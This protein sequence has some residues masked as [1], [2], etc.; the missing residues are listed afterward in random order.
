MGLHS[1]YA[2][3]FGDGLVVGSNSA[4]GRIEGEDEIL[5]VESGIK[6]TCT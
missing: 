4:L 3:G 5:H 1:G 2:F 6:H